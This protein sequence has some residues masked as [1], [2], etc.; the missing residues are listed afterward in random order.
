[1]PELRCKDILSVLCQ[2][3]YKKIIVFSISY[4][5]SSPKLGFRCHSETRPSIKVI[6]HSQ[7]FPT[8]VVKIHVT[9][10]AFPSKRSLNP[11]LTVKMK[12]NQASVPS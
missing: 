1:M 12:K 5:Q 9:S 7:L 4:I 2:C 10:A 6:H 11:T 3:H 8:N